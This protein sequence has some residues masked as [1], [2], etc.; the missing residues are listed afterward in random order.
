MPIEIL[1]C[2]SK[3]IEF[4]GLKGMKIERREAIIFNIDR[5]L[6]IKVI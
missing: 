5:I 1:E 6:K 2:K 4:V 3:N